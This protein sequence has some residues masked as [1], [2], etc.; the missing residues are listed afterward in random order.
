M[1]SRCLTSF[2]GLQSSNFNLNSVT[3]IFCYS[4]T[5]E[6]NYNSGRL[7]NSI[8]STPDGRITP[9][10]IAGF[11]PKFTQAHFEEVCCVELHSL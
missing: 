2:F 4:Y 5:L 9:P 3:L 6:C 1:S 11:P 10:P 8:A 7:V